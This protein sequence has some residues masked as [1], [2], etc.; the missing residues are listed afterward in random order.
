[1]LKAATLMMSPVGDDVGSVHTPVCDSYVCWCEQITLV[2][3]TLFVGKNF[4]PSRVQLPE[5]AKVMSFMLLTSH[6]TLFHVEAIS[7]LFTI[8]RK[9]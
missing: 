6:A 8:T 3:S 5:V 7:F 4:F 9:T 1:M 2:F